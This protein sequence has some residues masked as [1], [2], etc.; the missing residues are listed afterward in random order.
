MPG[1]RRR[2]RRQPRQV[3]LLAV[4]HEPP[5]TRRARAVEQVRHLLEARSR[6]GRSGRRSRRRASAKE[7]SR[8]ID[9]LRPSTETPTCRSVRSACSTSASLASWRPMI[10]STNVRLARLGGDDRADERAVAQHGDAV[11]DLA[12]LVEVVRDEEDASRRPPPRRGRART[13]A[14]SPSRGRNTV[15]SSSTSRPWPTPTRADLLDRADDRQ[16]RPLDR[17]QVADDRRRVDPHAVALERLAR[18]RPLAPPGDAEARARGGDL[19]H[20]QVLE[21]AQRLDRARDPGGR[22]SCPS[23]RNCPG[24][25][26]S[27]T[28]SPSISSS[29]SSGSW[30]PARILISVDL[31]EPFSPRRPWTSPGSTAQVDAAQRLRPA[32]ALRQVAQLEPRR[33][34]PSSTATAGPR[35]C[36]SR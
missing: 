33:S 8:T 10:I 12:H 7:T 17:L 31:P 3:D 34:A 29:P 35:A 15:G 9:P 26:G 5:G 11:G 25:S 27:R 20:A 28:G 14:R 22:S 6:S 23:S 36:G 21:H 19:G 18:P 32:E 30:K 2:G 13:A 16:Q 4:E 24:A 1:P